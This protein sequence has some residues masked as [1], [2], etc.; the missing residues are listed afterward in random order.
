MRVTEEMASRM[1]R[2]YVLG[3]KE[4]VYRLQEQVSSGK[5]V[6]YASDDPSSFSLIE[7]LRNSASSIDQYKLN[8]DRLLARMQNMDNKMRQVAE[9]LQRTSL[10]GCAATSRRTRSQETP[11]AR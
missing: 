10:P 1:V 2:H 8:A 4:S 9:I 3:N 6:K 5:R 7:R 11:T